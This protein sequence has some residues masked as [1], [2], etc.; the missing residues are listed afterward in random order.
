MFLG[1]YGL[2]LA[3]KRAAPRASL[4]ALVFA[5]QW[6]DELWPVLLLIGVERVRIAPGLMAASPLDF[7]SYPIS[8]SLLTALVFGLIA[9]GIYYALKRDSK[10]A[11]IFG[12][13]VPSHWLLDLPMHRPDLPLWPGSV[14][15]GLGAW[16]SV[17]LS[18]AIELAMFAGGA[19]I[20]LRATKPRD[21]TGTL[22]LVGLL[23]FLLLCY[24]GALFGP[25]PTSPQAIAWSALLLWLMIPWAA[26]IDRH[27]DSNGT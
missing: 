4:G 3:S 17:P 20:Y 23:A 18:V 2:A 13:L 5:A 27:R 25:P 19:F 22:A 21:R 12:A 1:H 11:L 8:H 14:K 7:E 6:L 24:A 10:S 16:N 9:G 15:V 26:W